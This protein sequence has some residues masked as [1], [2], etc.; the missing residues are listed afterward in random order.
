MPRLK[1]GLLQAAGWLFYL[2]LLMGLALALPTS[3]FDAESKN[4]IFLIGVVG[5]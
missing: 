2:T 3:I 5:I 1:N 4:F